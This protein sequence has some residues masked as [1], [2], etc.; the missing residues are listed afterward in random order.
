MKAEPLLGQ[1]PEQFGEGDTPADVMRGYY[2]TL[3]SDLKER[4]I[5]SYG[6]GFQLEAQLTAETVSG[7]GTFEPNRALDI[8][9]EQYAVLTGPLTVAGEPVGTLRL[10]CAQQGGEWKLLVVYLY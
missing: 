3:A 9:A 4:L 8:E 10:V 5:Q 1:H 6:R 7:T 2:R